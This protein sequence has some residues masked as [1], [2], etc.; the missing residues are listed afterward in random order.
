VSEIADRYR[1]LSEGFTARV[2]ATPPDRWDS[3]SPCEGWTARDVVG[4]LVG[5]VGF[6]LGLV[7]QKA[8]AG[9]S[10]Q[11]D[12]AGAWA[13][14]RDALQAVLDDPALAQQEFESQAMGGRMTLEQGVDRFGNFD[15]LVHTWDLA[16]ATGLD[17]TLD[18]DEV[19][20]A[21]EGALPMDEMMR[22]PGVCG[23]KLDAP[24]GADEQ[25]RFLA[26]LG[27]RV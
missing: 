3:P 22:S 12:P 1:R 25:T 10:V 26:F 15:L 11:D 18:P 4:H 24:E 14:A 7:G 13:A 17:E 9:P 23:P 8:P 27:R 19:H 6:F 20:R 21:F 16:R 2:T 5:N